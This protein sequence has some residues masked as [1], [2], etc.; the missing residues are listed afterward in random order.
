MPRSARPT[1][2]T[3]ALACCAVAALI[4]VLAAWNA[5]GSNPRDGWSWARIHTGNTPRSPSGDWAFHELRTVRAAFNL[6]QGDQTQAFRVIVLL[7]RSRFGVFQPWLQTRDLELLDLTG[8]NTDLRSGTADPQWPAIL[9]AAR[10]Y[11][12]QTVAGSDDPRVTQYHQRI[13][14]AIDTELAGGYPETTIMWGGL[15]MDLLY[16]TSHFA[17]LFA[18][19]MLA[20]R[21]WRSGL[22]QHRYIQR[23]CVHCGYDAAE[24]ADVC[25]ECGK[26]PR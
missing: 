17:M 9:R 26:P 1:A 3:I 16:I 6:S 10:D 23:R 14:D 2:R 19:F 8:R 22:K 4:G 11:H 20:K 24:P 15:V 18:L 7:R 13:V 5:A 12:A 25:P 21:V